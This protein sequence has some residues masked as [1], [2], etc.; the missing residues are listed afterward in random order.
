MLIS[1]KKFNEDQD[2]FCRE[3]GYFLCQLFYPQALED[4]DIKTEVEIHPALGAMLCLIA[5]RYILMWPAEGNWDRRYST[6][7]PLG[8]LISL[9]DLCQSMK[10]RT[11]GDVS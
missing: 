3:W 6:P 2:K 4:P 1:M 8:Q 7:P 9:D 5:E 10:I 11:A